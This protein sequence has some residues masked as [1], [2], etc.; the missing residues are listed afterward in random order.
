MPMLGKR[1]PA[2]PK[3][4]MPSDVSSMPRESERH[5]DA[6][7]VFIVERLAHDGR[8][9]A[10]A[11]TGKTVFVDAALPGE[12][13]QVAVHRTRKRFD[14][15]HIVAQLSEAA[16]RV[17]PPCPHYTRCG[18]CD[19]QHL[20][21]VEQRQ[22][23]IKVLQELFARQG[24]ELPGEVG[25]IAGHGS[26]YRRR[27]RLGV[28][29]DAQGA[30]HL[31][32]RARR[33][34]HLVDIDSCFV[35]TPSLARLLEPLR[36]QLEA[37]DAPRRVGHLELIDADAGPCVI[38]RQLREV[39]EDAE[40]WR[41]FAER[42]GVSVAWR[43]G[44]DPLVLTWLGAIP[45]LSVSL[46]LGERELQLGFAPGDFL[47]V[48]AEVNQALV[49]T[50]IDWLA[51]RGDERVLDLFA[52]VGNF[53]LALAP[54]VASITGIEGSQMM[55]ERLSQNARR[56]GLHQVDARQADLGSATLS[57]DAVDVVLLD[58]PRDGADS[59]CRALAQSDVRHILYVSCDPASLAR[60][61]AHLVQG[62]Y[63]I[64]RAAVADMFAHTAHL[65][66]V[67]LLTRDVGRRCVSPS[68]RGD[69]GQGS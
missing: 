4:V 58:P 6:S 55:T 68:G 42:H 13:V 45:D 15:A 9:V 51:P 57:F 32:F 41:A 30:V 27:A 50:A 62:G 21:L 20:A 31:G 46:S 53:T 24:L 47:Q 3:S 11:T 67:L 5:A 16:S 43:A 56:A 37:L 22:H 7:D 14:E 34:D 40:R 35:L 60:D 61:A 36:E 23:K 54:H 19:L 10:H 25:L 64:T 17:V 38:V 39:P 63:R 49:Q 59:V 28:K 29:V 33:S 66:S 1:R 52:G 18:G 69:N 12:R 26:G 44:R 2:K 65:E 48:N 8:G